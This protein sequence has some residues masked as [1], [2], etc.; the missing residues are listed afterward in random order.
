M[1][2]NALR[3]TF[4]WARRVLR[5]WRVRRHISD[6]DWRITCDESRIPLEKIELASDG[7]LLLALERTRIR[8]PK[9]AAALRIL[10]AYS[11]LRELD[12]Y[13]DCQ[14]SWNIQLDSLSLRWG[15]AIYL[16]D[17]Y[18]ELYI[19][20]EIYLSGDYDFA[21]GY[22]AVV[23]DVGANVGFTSIFLAAANP[24][25]LIV[26]CEP[27]GINFEKA[28]RNF[29]VNPCLSQRITLH[30]IGLFSE[31]GEQTVIS[32]TGSRGRSSIVL[33][34][35]HNP[36]GTTESIAIKVRRAS[37]FIR[38][39]KERHPNRRIIVKMDCEGSEYHILRNL[40]MD[41]ALGLV[42]GFVMEWHRLAGLDDGV[43]FIRNMFTRTGF[44]VCI[45]GRLQSKSEIGMAYAF[46]STATSGGTC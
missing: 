41:G 19:L 21:P 33:D 15:D 4:N 45:R 31:D 2:L 42:S 32:E 39:I 16:A 46:K 12:S 29:A 10:S 11:L 40:E 24:D 25:I 36:I 34:R 38:E 17:N 18:E 44:D 9:T 23:V 7:D 13:T 37:S 28:Q 30:N 6:P 43:E 1:N 22:S 26:G 8:L 5:G 3:Q 35:L 20:R 27:L 14:V